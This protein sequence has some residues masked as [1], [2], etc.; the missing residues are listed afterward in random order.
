MLVVPA[1]GLPAVALEAAGRGV[2]AA[3][4][5]VAAA[6]TVVPAVVVVVAVATEQP[7]SP[8]GKG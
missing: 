4:L 3:A 5:A 8:Q 7:G 2:V 6:R 1:E